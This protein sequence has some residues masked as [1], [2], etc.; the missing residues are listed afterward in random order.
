MAILGRKQ[1]QNLFVCS[2]FL[3]VLGSVVTPTQ[4]IGEYLCQSFT[5]NLGDL[6]IQ[7]GPMSYFR[8][9]I[10]FLWLLKIVLD[11]L[12]S[13][14]FPLFHF[15]ILVLIVT[16]SLISHGRGLLFLFVF[17]LAS[18]DV[19]IKVI[20]KI[21]LL[22]LTIS[23]AIISV[24]SVSGIIE[25]VVIGG[26]EWY[27]PVRRSLGF[28]NPNTLGL[29]ILALIYAC[30]VVFE[31]NLKS[32]LGIGLIVSSAFFI[33]GSRSLVVGTFSLF[34][35]Y[36]IYK[37]SSQ[38]VRNLIL[39]LFLLL[40]V[41]CLVF[42]YQFSFSPFESWLDRLSSFRF[43]YVCP[44]LQ[45]LPITLFGDAS[46]FSE[47]SDPFDN[48]YAWCLLVYGIVG[49][50]LFLG[51]VFSG[52]FK[53]SGNIKLLALCSTVCLVGLFESKMSDPVMSFP[54]VKVLFDG[55]DL[56]FLR[57]DSSS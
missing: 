12:D 25:D 2:L 22:S 15:L 31:L 9:G 53:N 18:N 16:Q 1:R 41:S 34:V 49:T 27:R 48:S 28:C 5:L 42:L 7:K 19:D 14:R 39:F 47:D 50:V 45:D 52:M 8:G 56:H 36:Y 4:G 33:S 3:F 51:A 13:K 38:K 46:I 32:L 35:T 55:L 29:Y 11:A 30:F 54:L 44:V 37:T 40:A 20:S 17:A 6:T 24:L 21:I 43:S 23:I 26:G 10:L 57:H